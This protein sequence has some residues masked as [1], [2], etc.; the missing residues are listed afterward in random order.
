MSQNGK[1][2][3]NRI[4]THALQPLNSGTDLSGNVLFGE[5]IEIYKIIS[6]YDREQQERRRKLAAKKFPI[7]NLNQHRNIAISTVTSKTHDLDARQNRLE[8]LLLD[9]KKKY[10]PKSVHKSI[11]PQ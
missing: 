3:Q 8:G 5:I 2:D 1:R 9:A 7:E 4:L 10:T 6:Y 11:C